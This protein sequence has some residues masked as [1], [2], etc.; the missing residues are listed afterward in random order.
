MNELDD[1]GEIVVLPAL[2]PHGASGQQYQRR[3]HAFATTANDVFGNLANQCHFRIETI[4]DDRIHGLHVRPD[5]GI[6]LFHGPI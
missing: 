4:A 5:Q 1:C 3:P 6:K 2:I